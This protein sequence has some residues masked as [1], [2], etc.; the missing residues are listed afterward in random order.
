MLEA[1]ILAARKFGINTDHIQL[2]ADTAKNI[3]VL[4]NDLTFLGIVKRIGLSN[5]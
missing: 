5:E 2:I 3:A 4:G 1:N